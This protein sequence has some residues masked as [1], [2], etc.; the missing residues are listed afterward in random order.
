MT[1]FL[2]V[3]GTYDFAARQALVLI[4][5]GVSVYLLLR[6]GLF[7]VPQ[8]G[9][10]AVGSYVSALLSLNQGWS[11]PVVLVCGAAASGLTGLVLGALLARLNGIYLAIATIGFS[12][13]VRVTAINLQVTGGPQ[14][15]FGIPLAANDLYIVGILA[16]ALALLAVLSRSRFGLAMS[17]MREEPLMARHQG[18]NIQLYRIVLFGASGAL[19]GTA[20]VLYVHLSG[21]IDPTTYSFDLLIQ[22]LAVVVLG[23]MTSVIGPLLGGCIVF[24]L[25]QALAV[26]EDY[27]N[28]VNGTLIVLVVALLP[29]GLAGAATW[30][31]RQ[32]AGRLQGRAHGASRRVGDDTADAP[33]VRV[34]GGDRSRAESIAATET[35]AGRPMLQL[36]D[37]AKHFGGIR[38]LQGVSL[39]VSLHEIFGII[40]PN[41]SGKTSLLNVLSGV[42]RPD[43][44]QGFVDGKPIA[45]W[46]GRPESL[47]RAGIART[48]QGIRLLGGH[49]VRDNV[50]L[51]AYL[52]RPGR[53]A[54]PLPSGPEARNGHNSAR[55]QAMQT[56]DELGLTPY[57]SAPAASLPYG[58]QRKVEIA[59]ALVSNPKLLLLDEPTAGMSPSERSEIFDLVQSVKE[60]GVTTVV[61]E[62]DVS[63]MSRYCHRL[64][65]LNFG[66]TITVGVP[67]TVM[68]N[69]EVI[70]AYIGRPAGGS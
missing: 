21:F 39:E 64:A 1:T 22:V 40:G 54:A 16:V 43:S 11:F 47:A 8:I 69:E 57:A 45:A 67:E 12:E 18:V 3:F 15:L 23:G 6:A 36:T 24:G 33:V 53:S 30:L 52:H 58:L 51:G 20:G 35:E 31:W 59:R 28:L 25:P 4:L 42:Y 13:V 32:S 50:L 5:V 62:H 26:F 38:A 2:D 70:G 56:I 34:T 49:S 37:V 14:G 46:W 29:G 63:V 19:A 48:F 55:D 7:A 60:R 44:G 27:R 9:F 66:R 65:V 68:Q 41:G 10:M 61:V 17:G